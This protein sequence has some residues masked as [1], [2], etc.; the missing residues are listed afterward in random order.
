MSTAKV[1]PKTHFVLYAY[2][3]PD[4]LKVADAELVSPRLKVKIGDTEQGISAGLTIDECAW[5]R[6]NQQGRTNESQGKRLLGAWLIDRTSKFNRDY[7]IAKLLKADGARG[8]D[9]LDGGGAEWYAF[10]YDKTTGVQGV[11]DQIIAYITRLNGAAPRN[12]LKL[13]DTHLRHLDRAIGAFQEWKNTRPQETFSLVAYLCPRFGKT[14]FAL[15][16]FKRANALFGYDMLLLPAYVLSAHTSFKD[17]VQ[18]YRDFSNM[19]FI[20][21]KDNTAEEEFQEATES[22]R[23]VVLT[24]S[25][26]AQDLNQFAYIRNAGDHRKFEFI[27]EADLGAWTGAKSI[28]SNS[29]FNGDH[30]SGSPIRALAS[31]TNIM[32]MAIGLHG[33]RPDLVIQEAYCTL[34]QN[35]PGTVKR[36]VYQM[37]LS[38]TDLKKSLEKGGNFSWGRFF[39]NIKTNNKIAR[40]LVR[41]MFAGT[42][43]RSLD[44]EAILGKKPEVVMMFCNGENSQLK[45]FNDIV[46]DELED[47]EVVLLTGDADATNREAENIVKSAIKKAKRNR[48]D[49][50]VVITNTIGNRSFSVSEVEACIMLFD[51]GSAG[52]CMQR[53]LRMGTPGFMFDGKTVKT[54]GAIISLS[55]DPAR[56]DLMTECY[57]DEART[58]M[59]NNPGISFREALRDYVFDSV[60]IFRKNPI[61]GVSSYIKIDREAVIDE[62][63]TMDVYLRMADA[64]A[65]FEYILGDAESIGILSAVVLTKAGKAVENSLLEKAE[66]YAISLKKNKAADKNTKPEKDILDCIRRALHTLNSSATTIFYLSGLWSSGR[67]VNYR[68][69]LELISADDVLDAEFAGLTGISATKAIVLLDKGVLKDMLLDEVVRSTAEDCEARL[70]K[71]K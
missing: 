7:K 46:V 36:N 70:A 21:T 24:I 51:R 30:S 69:A 45:A 32:R 40:E 18:K 48:K 50:V 49:G 52:T 65:D 39:A 2:T 55:I 10:D 57:M 20:D 54:H 42:K 33:R 25:M 17:E 14:I 29:L 9:D 56:D 4:H 26:H 44:L 47:Y 62:L 11:L 28:V 23:M 43:N 22:G 59:S 38:D 35:E 6:M 71:W 13:R 16:M 19:V 27:D 63:H 31:G 5:E 3:Y 60:N 68:S 1:D 53:A 58:V 64:C 12:V 15:E 8:D 61:E 67:S 41:G 37:S 66:T 34:E